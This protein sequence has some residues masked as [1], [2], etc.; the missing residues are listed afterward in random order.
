MSKWPLVQK[1]W[2]FPWY[3]KTTFQG[4]RLSKL[5]QTVGAL[6]SPSLDV[7][8]KFWHEKNAA[9]RCARVGSIRSTMWPIWLLVVSVLRGMSRGASIVKGCFWPRR[10]KI[11]PTQY[12]CLGLVCTPKGLRSTWRKGGDPG[13]IWPLVVSVLRGQKMQG[14]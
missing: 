2:S 3:Q 9:R 12:P 4:H 5:G 13:P 11:R 14:Q 7:R 10:A 1:L 8:L 6:A